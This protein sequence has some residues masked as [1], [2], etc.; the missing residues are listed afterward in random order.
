MREERS[1]CLEKRLDRL[2]DHVNCIASS[3]FSRLLTFIHHPQRQMI[4]K[5]S[6]SKQMQQ[7]M[8][9]QMRYHA[10]MRRAR[11]NGSR[12]SNMGS[13]ER[14]TDPAARQHQ[15]QQRRR[16]DDIQLIVYCNS[17]HNT[18]TSNNN[19]TNIKATTTTTQ[20]NNDNNS[21]NNNDSRKR[22]QAA[23]LLPSVPIVLGI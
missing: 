17:S 4:S 11:R 9:L 5:A 2:F 22:T 1:R 23:D 18:T 20:Q 19:T 3:E 13:A 10:E 21:D 12:C 14:A 6:R 15:M 8:W 16:D 7:H